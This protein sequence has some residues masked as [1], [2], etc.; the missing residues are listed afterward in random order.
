MNPS[1]GH[2]RPLGRVV[3]L[4]VHVVFKRCNSRSVGVNLVAYL[5]AKQPTNYQVQKKTK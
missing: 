5:I 2:R 3:N 1:L 4:C